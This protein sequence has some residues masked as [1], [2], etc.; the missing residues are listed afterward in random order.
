MANKL[1]T[2]SAV[3][4]SGTTKKKVYH[5]HLSGTANATCVLKTGGTAGTAVSPVIR[6]LANESGEFCFPGGITCDYVTLTGTGVN[7]WVSYS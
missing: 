4:H 6:V 1:L 2:A 3:V 7:C 5:V